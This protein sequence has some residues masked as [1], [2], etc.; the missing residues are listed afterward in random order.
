MGETRTPTVIAETAQQFSRSSAFRAPPPDKTCRFSGVTGV[1]KAGQTGELLA[2]LRML[3]SGSRFVLRITGVSIKV[4]ALD[5]HDVIDQ[6]ADPFPKS[7][8]GAFLM[9]SQMRLQL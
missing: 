2:S 5:R 9:F 6:F 4:L 7:L 1:L 8:E 3:E